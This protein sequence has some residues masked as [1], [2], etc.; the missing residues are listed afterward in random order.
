VAEALDLELDLVVWPVTPGPAAEA[1]VDEEGFLSVPEACRLWRLGLALDFDPVVV[2][3]L[4]FDFAFGLGRKCGLR[5]PG[6][7]RIRSP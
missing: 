5:G 1:E 7:R 4:S 3:D 6:E 2:W